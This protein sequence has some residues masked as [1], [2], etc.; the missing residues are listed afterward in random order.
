[1]VL[2][3][4]LNGRSRHFAC[5][6]API[7]WFEEAVVYRIGSAYDAIPAI[8]LARAGEKRIGPIL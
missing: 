1:M 7:L 5:I 4:R 2:L 8:G 6:S 3:S